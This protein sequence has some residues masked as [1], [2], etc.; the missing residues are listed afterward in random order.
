M[1]NKC[2][3]CHFFTDEGECRIAGRSRREAPGYFADACNEFQR[4]G[5]VQLEPLKKK[6]PE[7][8]KTCK[9]CGRTLPVENF[10]KHWRGG[11]TGYCRECWG[12]RTS[13]KRGEATAKEKV[14]GRKKAA[15][16]KASKAKEAAPAAPLR[17]DNIQ[18]APLDALLQELR[19]RGYRSIS[20]TL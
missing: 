8:E 6:G 3:D 2:K 4:I 11:Y 14:P 18:D 9:G 13:R 19:R 15:S 5:T 7:T 12:A 17:R 1:E 10:V 16:V 20:I